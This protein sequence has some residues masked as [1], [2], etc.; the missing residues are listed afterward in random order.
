MPSY[1]PCKKNDSNGY[2]FY[3]SLVSQSN[4]AVFQANPTLAVGDIKVAV[5]DGSPENVNAMA[6]DADFTKRVKI[7]LSQAQT[8]GDNLTIIC[9]DVAGAE[10]C[11]LTCNIQTAA[12][13]LDE[14]DAVAD[15]IQTQVDTTGVALLAGAVDDIWDEVLT[16]EAHNDATSAGRRL[17]QVSGH[18]LRQETA[19]SGTAST[20]TLDG[21]A[22]TTE[23]F[24]K[25]SYV[26]LIGGT[27][28][29][30]I[31][32]VEHYSTG[33]VCTIHPD[34]KTTPSSDSEYIIV[35]SGKVH[36]HEIDS[37]GLAQISAQVA[38]ELGTYDAATGTE[39]S[40]HDGKLDTA[41]AN[42]DKIL[43]GMEL[44]EAVY[45]W[46]KNALEEAPTGGNGG[47]AT[48]ANQETLI[49]ILTGKWEITGNQLIMYDTDGSTALYTFDLTRDGT[50]TEFN[51]DKREAA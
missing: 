17:R 2:V 28:S 9:S 4:G 12:Q 37:D 49:Q 7:T 29:G 10:W 27:G 23:D 32:Y 8:N 42:I 5:D 26:A 31:R 39:L 22:S 46:T 14:M 24:Y 16:G 43:T 45:R 15:G 35:G 41:D 11:D 1:V 33:R 13:T 19:A 40:N 50:P 30:Q 21:S 18:I 3:I 47:D 36:V 48:I 44:D 20:I 34:W 25:Y 51:P 6:V 38:T